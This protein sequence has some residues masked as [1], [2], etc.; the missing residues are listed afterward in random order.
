[1]PPKIHSAT[2]MQKR[3]CIIGHRNRA[4]ANPIGFL[5]FLFLV[6]FPSAA[7]AGGPKL[8][9]G[10]AGVLIAVVLGVIG[11]LS[12]LSGDSDTGKGASRGKPRV[13]ARD[14]KKPNPGPDGSTGRSRYGSDVGVAVVAPESAEPGE[15][16]MVQVAV[17]LARDLPE[18][19][20]RA[21]AFDAVNAAV[22]RG[23]LVIHNVASGAKLEFQLIIQGLQV[24]EMEREQYQIWEGQPFLVQFFALVPG[25]ARIGMHP[26]RLLVSVD[27]CPVGRVG[28]ALNVIETNDG[29]QK[30]AETFSHGYSQYFVSYSDKDFER[31]L[32][33]VQGL[34]IGGLDRDVQFFSDKVSLEPGERFEAEIFDYIDNRADAFLLFWS[35]NSAASEW[36]EKEWR[37]ALARQTGKD[38]LPDII[39]VPLDRHPP[40]PPKALAPLPFGDELMMISREFPP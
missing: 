3:H 21:K 23:S 1:M 18:T 30:E 25:N 10:P 37:R 29:G 5:L 32:P 19:I 28:F 13:S 27:G 24:D 38:G 2:P 39:P 15:N 20:R 40:P 35:A 34:R 16:V 9:K 4:I 17:N 8:P 22:E 31:V 14:E 7:L 12:S 11:I 36:V 26:A 6:L 33:R